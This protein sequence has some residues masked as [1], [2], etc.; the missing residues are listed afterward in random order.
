[1]RLESDFL[2]QNLKI[3]DIALENRNQNEELRGMKEKIHQMK[4]EWN[5]QN[6]KRIFSEDDEI[7]IRHKGPVRL[8]PAHLFR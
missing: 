8:L 1:M 3:S 7:G 2:N 4:N 5:K 6:N